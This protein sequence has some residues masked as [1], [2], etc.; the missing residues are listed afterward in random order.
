MSEKVHIKI[1]KCPKIII[2][3]FNYFYTKIINISNRRNIMFEKLK[4]LFVLSSEKAASEKSSENT[5]EETKK[6]KKCLRRC[7]L[8]STR[9]PHCMSDD[10]I[11]NYA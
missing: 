10:F 6:C 9:C 3:S 8:D 4:S 2:F 1:L 5:P 11:Y 7:K